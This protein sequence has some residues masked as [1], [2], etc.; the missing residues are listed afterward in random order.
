MFEV[1]C[2]SSEPLDTPFFSENMYILL[3]N[4]RFFALSFEVSTAPGD[5]GGMNT[6]FFFFKKG[7]FYYSSKQLHPASA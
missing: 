1:L 2:T 6:N 5:C 3:M 4:G 7:R